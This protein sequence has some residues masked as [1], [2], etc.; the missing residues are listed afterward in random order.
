MKKYQ[1]IYADPPWKYKIDANCFEKRGVNRD[2]YERLDVEQ[3]KTLPI[4]KIC[5]EKCILF[6]W[7]G[8]PKLP[9]GIEVMKSWGFIYV[10]IGF[11]WVKTYKDGKPICGMGFYTR[12]G[13]EICLIGRKPK[14]KFKRLDRNILQVTFSHIQRHSQKPAIFRNKIVSLFGDLP[15]IELFARK[16]EALFEDKSFNGWDVWGNEVESDI[17]LMG[18][19]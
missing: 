4:Q 7:V 3:L 2:I 16:P 18:N 9:E 13:S 14:T 19:K 6:L 1:I 17:D 12:M 5:D 10:T 11:N 15:R 8:N